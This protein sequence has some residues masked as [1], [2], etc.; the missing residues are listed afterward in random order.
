MGAPEY[1]SELYDFGSGDFL[2]PVPFNPH[3]AGYDGYKVWKDQRREFL[4]KINNGNHVAADKTFALDVLDTEY[5]VDSGTTEAAM[6]RYKNAGPAKKGRADVTKLKDL[7]NS[8][9][10]ALARIYMDDVPRYHIEAI[11][12]AVDHLAE[13]EE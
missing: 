4:L 6:D 8:H 2:M 11:C 3:V 7:V 1:R 5:F 13:T 12:R 9:R 10:A